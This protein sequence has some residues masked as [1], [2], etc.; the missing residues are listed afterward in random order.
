MIARALGCGQSN[1]SRWEN[2]EKSL[3]IFEVENLAAL[4]DLKL[5]DFHSELKDWTVE[6]VKGWKF[7]AYL[8]DGV[9]VSFGSVEFQF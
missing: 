7:K 1:L 6:Q 4:Y 9:P 3:D 8:V 5:T 2:G